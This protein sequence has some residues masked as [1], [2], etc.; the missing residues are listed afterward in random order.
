MFY[1]AQILSKKG[2]LAVIWLAAHMDNRLKKA[3]VFDTNI[4]GTVG[5]SLPSYI[6]I[7][8]DIPIP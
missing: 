7:E 1:S 2:A 5:M 4:V 8:N 3:N 6:C